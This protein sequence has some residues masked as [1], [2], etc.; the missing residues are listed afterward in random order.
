MTYITYIAYNIQAT[1]VFL[2]TCGLADPEAGEGRVRPW[3][4]HYFFLSETEITVRYSLTE[5][6]RWWASGVHFCLLSIYV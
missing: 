2:Y 4:I 1:S 3:P 5:D 6:E